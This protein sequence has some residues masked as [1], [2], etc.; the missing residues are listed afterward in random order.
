MPD[1]I[2]LGTFLGEDNYYYKGVFKEKDFERKQVIE[3]S[4]DIKAIAFGSD[5]Y[6]Y[7]SANKLYKINP[8]TFSIVA[9]SSDTGVSDMVIGIN[10][11]IY[12]V[13]S[14]YVQKYNP[15][16]LTQRATSP[17]VGSNASLA[18]SP[19][20][21]VYA[22]DQSKK[23][24]KILNPTT[25]AITA[26]SSALAQVPYSIAVN[27]DAV[28]VGGS[29]TLGGDVFKLDST[30]LAISSYVGE[31]RNPYLY[32]I[33]LS[34]THVY[35]VGTT[36]S[37]TSSADVRMF[38]LSNLADGD[39]VPNCPTHSDDVDYYDIYI[40]SDGL[41]IIAGTYLQAYKPDLIPLITGHSLSNT[42]LIN[43]TEDNK[44]NLYLAVGRQIFKVNISYLLDSYRRIIS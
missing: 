41:V 6:L 35:V 24:V 30:T 43:M 22:C 3:M 2:Y 20:G 39:T 31:T 28:Y 42:K 19:N 10:G 23:T 26:T 16:T 34:D 11:D 12:C 27:N 36:R 25:L 13:R 4:H 44:K 9:E 38:S 8:E 32:G 5:G 37:S 21:N 33:A 17:S 1:K 29:D 7:V 40:N 14:P 18:V 15:I